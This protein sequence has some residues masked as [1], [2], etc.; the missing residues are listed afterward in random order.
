MFNF[1]NKII[2][3][4]KFKKK[5]KKMGNLIDKNTE[6]YGEYSSFKIG[7]NNRISG[8]VILST[9]L[10][11][12][13]VI[14]DCCEIHPGAMLL[15]Y[16]GNIII[17]N[18]CS[19]NPYTIIYGHGDVQIGNYVRIAAHTILIPANHSY[20]DRLPIHKQPLIKKGIL[21]MDD[22]WIG[23]NVTIL[24]GITIGEGSVIGAGAVV[25]KDVEPYTINAGVPAR[26]IKRRHSNA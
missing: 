9:I 21:I 13:L 26:C 18:F 19:V 1:F 6:F 16:G 11:G 22:V 10:G 25:T 15:T 14:G 7:R 8:K 3:C 12:N 17:G 24:D 4:F 2:R 20:T 23:A 5:L